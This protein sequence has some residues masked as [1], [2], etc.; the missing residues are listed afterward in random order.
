MEPE[1]SIETGV[2][3]PNRTFISLTEALWL[4]GGR[5]LDDKASDID[6]VLTTVFR[7]RLLE[8]LRASRIVARGRTFDAV[9]PL[10]DPRDIPRTM[11]EGDPQDIPWTWFEGDPPPRVLSFDNSLADDSPLGMPTAGRRSMGMWWSVALRR[12]DII[13]LYSLHVHWPSVRGVADRLLF[14]GA[15][16]VTRN[17]QVGHMANIIMQCIEYGYIPPYS[18]ANNTCGRPFEDMEEMLFYYY[19][20]KKDMSSMADSWRIDY[21]AFRRFCAGE[22]G[23]EWLRSLEVQGWKLSRDI[24]PTGSTAATV[25]EPGADAADRASVESAPRTGVAIRRPLPD[26]DLQEWVRGL[27]PNITQNEAY[28][29]A[30]DHFPLHHVARN[31]VRAALAAT[32]GTWDPGPRKFGRNS[33]DRP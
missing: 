22:A 8:P 6:S 2:L 25:I 23:R 3:L 15:G 19:T 11:F 32:H 16:M 29:Q 13:A 5:D 4:L 18:V 1:S 24:L 7:D 10:G 17:K 14:A 12:E 27:S 31:R 9:G 28:T 21:E 30:I 20:D 26:A 33:A